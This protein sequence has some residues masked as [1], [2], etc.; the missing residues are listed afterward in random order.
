MKAL[1]MAGLS[2]VWLLG[3]GHA[4]GTSNQTADA[5]YGACVAA[6]EQGSTRDWC[7]AYCDCTMDKTRTEFTPREQS[8]FGQALY[9]GGEIDPAVATRFR[10]IILSCASQVSH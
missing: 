7:Q 2:T 8:Q 3:A 1:V 5:G 4:A 9:F 10:E 6:C